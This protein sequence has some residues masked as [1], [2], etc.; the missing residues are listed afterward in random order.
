MTIEF[1]QEDQA[2]VFY[3]DQG[4]KLAEITWIPSEE[5]NVVLANHTYVSPKLRGQ[6][7]AGQLL[8]AMVDLMNK[9]SIKIK[10]LCSYVVKQFQANPSKYDF[11][12]ANK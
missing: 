6:G 5:E 12:N 4:E 7:V 1:Q 10:P 3:N 2:L 11:I 9:Q 8:D